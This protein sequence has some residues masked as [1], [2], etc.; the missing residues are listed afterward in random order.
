M[1]SEPQDLDREA[2]AEGLKRHWRIDAAHLE[3]LPVGFGSHH[4][5]AEGAD[6]SRWFVSADDL[7]A[8]R[9]AGEAPEEA[10]T[11]LDRAYRTA[12][13]L[14]VIAGLEFVQAPV[15]SGD[16]A[17]AH[18]LGARYAIR[19]EPFVDGPA[20]GSG[21]YER[22]HERG[23]MGTLIGRL[24]AASGSVPPGLPRREEFALQ[25]RPELEQALVQLETPWHGGPFAEPARTLLREHAE[26]VRDR[27]QAYDRLAG[28][29]RDAPG[30]WVVTHGEPHSA[31]VI[32]DSRD[33]LR[34]VDWDTTLVAPRERDLWVVLDAE[35]TGWYEYREAAGSVAL[36]EDALD[37]YRE[38]WALAEICEYVTRFR[39]PHNETEDTR[40]AWAELGEY[41]P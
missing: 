26:A 38:R 35:G 21:D 41:L 22:L 17:V 1:Y 24:H 37:L 25:G 2:L 18:R 34:L 19:V 29:I 11:A 5:E 32:R 16:G 39:R 36:N 9:H 12:S 40:A 4:W 28:H 14:R 15:P 6:G 7:R 31:N 33:N 8:G 27:L 30:A 20:L 3:Y 10:I 13:M 23:Q